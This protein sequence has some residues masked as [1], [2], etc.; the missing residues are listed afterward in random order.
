MRVSDADREHVAE[1][2]RDH[3]A[4]GRLTSAE[5]DE[6]LAAALSAKTVQDLSDVMADLP[7]PA[8]VGPSAGQGIPNVTYRPVYRYR[9]GPG[10]LP[11]ALIVLFAVLILPSAGFVF[12]A[13]LKLMLLFWL[14]ASVAGIFAAS[15][16]RRRARR[17]WQ[18]GGRRLYQDE[19]RWYHDER[20]W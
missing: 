4:A 7:E 19:R 16:V 3:F 18:S 8:P 17:Y 20:R 11:L 12:L 1:R 13:F 15:R 10:F 9:R 14:V 2:L 6:R 5:L